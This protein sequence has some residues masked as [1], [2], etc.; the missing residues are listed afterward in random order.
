MYHPQ[1]SFRLI[2]TLNARTPHSDHQKYLQKNKYTIPLMCM[3]FLINVTRN[4]PLELYRI[5]FFVTVGFI[6]YKF[7]EKFLV[8]RVVRLE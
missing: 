8:A 4:L 3:I 2:D 1:R 6:L 7:T 5:S